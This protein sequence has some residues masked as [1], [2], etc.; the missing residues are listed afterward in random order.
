[1]WVG[2]WVCA[3]MHVYISVTP[4]L[5]LLLTSGVICS[6]INY[7]RLPNLPVS[8]CTTYLL[9]SSMTSGKGIDTSVTASGVG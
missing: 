4:P 1:M 6:L 5:K 9:F 2:G 7:V 8:H 3:C